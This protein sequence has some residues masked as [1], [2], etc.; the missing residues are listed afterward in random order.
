MSDTEQRPASVERKTK[1]TEIN[2]QLVIDG[3]GE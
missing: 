1:E 3:S 2:V